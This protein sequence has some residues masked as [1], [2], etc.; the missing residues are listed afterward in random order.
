MAKK[1]KNKRKTIGVMTQSRGTMP[2]PTVADVVKKRK[3]D[4]KKVKEKLKRGD[5]DI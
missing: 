2:P 5:Y 4:R 3:N 1:K